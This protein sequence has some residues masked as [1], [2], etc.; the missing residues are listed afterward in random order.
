MCDVIGG[1][2]K[3]FL[4]VKIKLMHII[5][6]NPTSYKKLGKEIDLTSIETALKTTLELSNSLGNK[7]ILPM[8]DNT[9]SVCNIEVPLGLRG[10]TLCNNR[11]K[12]TIEG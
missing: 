8:I 1:E 9:A 5:E 11:K 12:R 7:P 3:Q 2:E 6:Q 4:M 10:F